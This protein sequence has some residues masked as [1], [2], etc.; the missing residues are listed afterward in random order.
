MHPPPGGVAPFLRS[1]LVTD[2][3]VTKILEAYFWE[4]VMVDTLNQGLVT[5]A[6]DI[7]WV[8]VTAG[9]QVLTRQ[10]QLRGADTGRIY[11]DAFSVIRTERIP[12]AFRQRLI[13]REI[14]IGVLIRDSG[15]R[16]TARSWRLGCAR[17][18][19]RSS[20]PTASSSTMPR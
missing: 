16:A 10:A 12:M 9:D 15:W 20:A 1:L 18:G 3:T 8:E 17:R 11:A 2:G 14:G 19:P 7:P 5:T 6:R 13:D 4:P